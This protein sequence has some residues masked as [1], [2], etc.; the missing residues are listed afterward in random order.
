MRPTN[1][2]VVLIASVAL[3][4]GSQ[5][6]EAHAEATSSSA[7]KTAPIRA[8]MA[9]L[10]SADPLEVREGFLEMERLGS[11]AAPAVTTGNS[12]LARGLPA[13]LAAVALRA[14]AKVGQESSS[15]VIRPYLHHRQVELR[16]EAVRALVGTKGQVAKDGLR[17]ALSDPDP[18]V[19]GV[20]ATG[21]GDLGAA[22]HVDALLVALDQGVFQ[23]AASV[24]KLCSPEQCEVYASR[25]GRV[26]FEVMASG[27]EPMLFRD[28]KQ[29][30]DEQK[31]RIVGR[32][33]DVGTEQA[34]E[35]L[36]DVRGRWPRKGSQAVKRALDLALRS[37]QGSSGGEP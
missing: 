23:A 6:D 3:F 36:M 37:M 25:M 17:R 20:A 15:R 19:R 29:I 26:A 16:R 22:E 9:L 5:V 18:E 32:V 10:T 7:R 31:I 27:F 12:V 13:E 34:R 24:G 14:L 11:K 2:A 35:F 28:A 8:I 4:A 33:R 30:S 1:F 21:L